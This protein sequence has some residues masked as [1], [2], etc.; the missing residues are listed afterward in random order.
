MSLSRTRRTLG[1][2]R[3]ADQRVPTD[4]AI[5]AAATELFMARGYRAVTMD[6][7]A[8]AAGVT[9]PAVYYHFGDKAALFTA[10]AESIFHRARGATTALL[11]ADLTLRQ[12]L[13]EIATIVLALPQPFTAFDAMMHE[14]EADLTAE[15]IAKIRA[16]ERSVSDLIE[17]ALLQG[18]KRGEVRTEDPV[19]IAHAFLGVLR[20]GQTRD[21]DGVR[22]F[23][24]AAQTATRLIDALWDGI[25]PHDAPRR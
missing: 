17:D 7:V 25:D 20:V 22:R 15:Q 9:K 24:D 5:I 18:A 6:M 10:V 2:P 4:V 12:R 13:Q 14:A 1:R 23:P 8:E 16:N 3:R 21:A 11:A 19:L